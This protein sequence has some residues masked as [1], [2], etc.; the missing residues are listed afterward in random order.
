MVTWASRTEIFSFHFAAA[1]GSAGGNW[2]CCG[3]FLLRLKLKESVDEPYA[4]KRRHTHKQHTL[5]EEGGKKSGTTQENW[6]QAQDG[7]WL[8]QANQR[9]VKIEFLQQ[10]I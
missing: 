3:D 5:G 10:L 6:Q 1:A 7:W 8:C 4:A 2:I 9:A